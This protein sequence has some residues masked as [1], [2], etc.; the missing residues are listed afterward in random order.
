[1]MMGR[2]LVQV[3]DVPAGNVFAVGGLTG[4]I[5]RN[6][7]LCGP[8][9]HEIPGNQDAWDGDRAFIVNLAGMYATVSVFYCGLTAF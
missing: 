8:S 2:E 5:L 4:A 9:D 6:G 3:N 1:M 7:T